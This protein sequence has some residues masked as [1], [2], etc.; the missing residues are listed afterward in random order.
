MKKLLPIFLLLVLSTVS[1]TKNTDDKCPSCE[2]PFL[3]ENQY[4]TY[5]ARKGETYQY[6]GR[7]WKYT[8]P[9]R[10]PPAPQPPLPG[11]NPSFWE[12]CGT[13]AD[14]NYLYSVT[15]DWAPGIYYPGQKVKHNGKVFI[16]FGQG[17]GAPE[18][19]G[20][21]IWAVMCK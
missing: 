7:C 12:P 2:F 4:T 18:D 9:T 10:I 21:D 15:A 14:C 13:P 16:C 20:D 1:C 5:L 3:T 8:G 19:P 6:D 11:T 17:T